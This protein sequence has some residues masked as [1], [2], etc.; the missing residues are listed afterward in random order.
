[1][2]ASPTRSHLTL[3]VVA[4]VVFAPGWYGPGH[5]ARPQGAD[6]AASML[7]PTWDEAV[8]RAA[9]VKPQPGGQN[10]KRF[11]PAA[12]FAY[13]SAFMPD[14]LG[15]ALFWLIA[16]SR[17]RSIAH[18]SCSTALSRAPPLLQLA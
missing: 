4:V 10:F 12:N 15:L 7:A 1:M 5:S 17:M 9:E 3:F 6:L 18:F 8:T 11:P 16:C 2:K 13:L 14:M